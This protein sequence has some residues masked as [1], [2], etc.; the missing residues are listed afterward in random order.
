[1]LK[2]KLDDLHTDLSTTRRK[3]VIDSNGISLT[4]LINS[5]DTL[6]CFL[7]LPESIAK[8]PK[9][10]LNKKYDGNRLYLAFY[11]VL[12]KGWCLDS[13][14]CYEY[15]FWFRRNRDVK[16][17]FFTIEDLEKYIGLFIKYNSLNCFK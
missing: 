6:Q 8:A 16:S 14:N 2:Y 3:I 11:Y 7:M 17:I 4:D 13:F 5:S 10:G 1:M 15:Y 9:L 12:N